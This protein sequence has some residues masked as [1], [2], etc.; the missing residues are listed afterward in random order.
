MIPRTIF[1]EEHRIFR[2]TVRRVIAREVVPH[3]DVWERAGV[4]PS[5]AWQTAGRAGLLLCAIDEAQGGGGGNFLHSAIVI[6]E[7]ARVG[8]TGPCFALHSDVVAPYL[9]HFA[10][11]NLKAKWLPRMGDGSAPGAIAMTEPD[12]GSDL[13]SMRTALRREGDMLIIDGSK[14]YISNVRGAAFV[15]VV[16]QDREKGGLSIVLVETD[17]PGFRLGRL[18]EKIGSHAQDLS[19]LYFADCRVPAQNLVGVAGEGMHHLMRMLPQERLVQA[20]RAVAAAEAMLEWTLEHV[21]ARHVFG[22]PLA[23]LQSVGFGLA[24][25]H[26]E[27]M[28]QRVLVDRC[29][30]LHLRGEMSGALA[31]SVKMSS[32]EMQG[33]VADACLQLFGAAGYLRETPIARA[34]TDAR[35]TRIAGGAVDIMKLVVSRHLLADDASDRRGASG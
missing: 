21:R 23:E 20:V 7:L 11:D 29:L 32:C 33:R 1:D 13:R 15:I 5:I 28:A 34:F 30:E 2:Q 17:R 10:S 8:A 14:C 24:E 22:R 6:E 27:I 19:E 31:A 35:Q 16:C 26:A 12:S 9:S 3:H 4:V 18:F 25:R